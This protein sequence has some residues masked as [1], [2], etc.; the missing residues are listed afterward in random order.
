MA[1]QPDLFQQHPGAAPALGGGDTVGR[2]PMLGLLHRFDDRGA[3]L[4]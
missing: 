3:R 2:A 1:G 4:P